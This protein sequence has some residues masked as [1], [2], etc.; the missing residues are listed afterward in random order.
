MLDVPATLAARVRVLGSSRSN[1]NDPQR[2]VVG[3][4]RSVARTSPDPGRSRAIIRACC[5]CSRSAT[6]IW[7]GPGTGPR[8]GSMRC[9]P[10]SWRAESP[11]KSTRTARSG[12]S[13][14]SRP[15]SP[16]ERTRHDV[17]VRAS[18]GPASPRRADAR[19]EEAARGGGQRV[20]HHAHRTLRGRSGRRRDGDRPHRRR[21]PV[22]EP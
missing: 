12:S 9:S 3:R 4:D 14:R 18:R 22:R 6:V 1:K 8:V 16:V 19:L 21:S 17:G 11:R 2:R 5:G 7:V 15:R 10:S 20:G 13:T